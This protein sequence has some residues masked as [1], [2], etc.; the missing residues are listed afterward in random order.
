MVGGEGKEK[1]EE[2]RVHREE[3]SRKEGWCRVEH[4]LHNNTL[5]KIR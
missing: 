5:S 4:V 1:G 2:S 3:E